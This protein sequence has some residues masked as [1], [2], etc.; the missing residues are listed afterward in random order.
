[1]TERGNG[2]VVPLV[3]AHVGE[4]ILGRPV[5]LAGIVGQQAEEDR[6]DLRTGD[7]AVRPHR[8]VLIADDIGHTV[9]Y[10][11]LDVYKRQVLL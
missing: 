2:V 6:C 7:P 5:P 11:H 8:A 3:G 1:M 10:T 4:V 9:S